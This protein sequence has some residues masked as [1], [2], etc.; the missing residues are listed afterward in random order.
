MPDSQSNLVNEDPR[1]IPWWSFAGAGAAF[2]LVEY[3][4][5]LVLPEAHHHHP[6]LGLRIY[7]NLSW[8]LLA[9]LYFLMI[10]YVSKD[11]PRR[12][13][14]S[15]FWML[16][17]F[18]LPGG[19]GAVLYFLLRQPQMTRCPACATHVQNDFHFCPQ[20]NYQLTASCGNCYRTVRTTDQFCTRCGHELGRD[21]R[22]SRLRVMGE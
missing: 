20:C 8:G 11:A 3:Y 4:F 17:C 15:K 16:I 12:G 13:M 2:L 21:Q 18:V 9:A 19:I 1:L 22:P 7:F 14:S 10:G 5:W 6:P